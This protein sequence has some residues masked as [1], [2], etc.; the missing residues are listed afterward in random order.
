MEEYKERSNI[1]SY[2]IRYVIDFDNLM[3]RV[4]FGG[5]NGYLGKI[6]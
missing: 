1:Y 5:E 2:G 4:Y 6:I 3:M